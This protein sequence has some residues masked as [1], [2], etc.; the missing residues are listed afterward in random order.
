YALSVANYRSFRDQA[1]KKLIEEIGVTG[2]NPV[3]PDLAYSLDVNK[4]SAIYHH[5]KTQLVV[6]I[7][8][9]PYYNSSYWPVSYPEV[10]KEYIEKMASFDSW[11]IYN[12]YK[13]L[14]FPTQIRADI[15]VIRDIVS[16]IIEDK[17]L[18]FEENISECSIS[19][20]EDLVCQLSTV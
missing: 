10:Y 17:N 9:F 4:S 20:V 18:N 19:A 1:S 13:V 3:F 8:P 16:I 5:T 11:L 15:L 6:G 2:E 14:F 12:N 7:N